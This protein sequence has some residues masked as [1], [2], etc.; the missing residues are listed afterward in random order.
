MVQRINEKFGLGVFLGESDFRLEL[1][2]QN[3]NTIYEICTED[4]LL[5][6]NYKFLR[7]LQAQYVSKDP[8]YLNCKKKVCQKYVLGVC[9]VHTCSGSITFHVVN[10]RTD[11][12][13][14]FFTG[15]FDTPCI[16]T[17]SKPLNFSNPKMP[18]H[19]HLSSIDSSRTSVSNTFTIIIK[20]YVP[21]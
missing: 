3:S 19:G 16:L 1:D 17:R 21:N 14:V 6:H 2:F 18:L 13:F 9:V 11:I 12:E 8:G 15:G 4:C 10:I 5:Q 20:V 7:N